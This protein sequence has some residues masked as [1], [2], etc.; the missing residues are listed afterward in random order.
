M[1]C[2]R[3]SSCLS[4]TDVWPTVPRFSTLF[5]LLVLSSAV[6]AGDLEDE[7]A[8]Q[9]RAWSFTAGGIS[10]VEI[11][12]WQFSGS[13]GQWDATEARESTS[14]RVS[15]TG[16]LWS[17]TVRPDGIFFNRFELEEEEEGQRSWAEPEPVRR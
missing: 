12:E 10:G 6:S 17:Y 15:L 9:I 7:E 5:V 11:D 4:F 16:G 13:F 3:N 14:G 1:K 2:T 8:F